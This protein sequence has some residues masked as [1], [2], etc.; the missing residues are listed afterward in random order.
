VGSL[1][2]SPQ[3]EAYYLGVKRAGDECGASVLANVDRLRLKRLYEQS[4]IFWHAAGYKDAGGRPELSEHFG[5]A[6]VEAMAAGC[7][8]IVINK[9]GQAEIVEHGES[10]FLWDTI[11]ELEQYTKLL[12]EDEP[13]RARMAESARARAQLYSREVF[14]SRFLRLLATERL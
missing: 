2:E 1:G 11:E 10:G 6:T 3:D 7:I 5:M 4:K 12:A 13:L 8:P 14:K 9:G